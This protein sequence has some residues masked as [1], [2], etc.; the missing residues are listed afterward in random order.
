M[1]HRYRHGLPHE[2][3]LL[4]EKVPDALDL[5]AF[6]AH[7]R[8]LPAD[9]RRALLRRLID[10][11]AALIAAL[12]ERRLSHRDLK[13]ANLLV[14]DV[15]RLTGDEDICLQL[16]DLV[17]VRRLRKLRRSRRLQNLARLNA[18]FHDHPDLTRSDRLRFLRVYLHWGT[19][20]RMGWKRWWRQIEEATQ[21]KARR[22]RRSGRPLR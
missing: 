18:S 22:N 8:T 6:L 19:R 11:V 3:Y 10:R 16:I 2:G 12:H 13:A 5:R 15:S 14:R 7:L 4:T 20:G 17:G 9:A 1:W 21:A